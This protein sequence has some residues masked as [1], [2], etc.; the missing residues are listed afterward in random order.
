MGRA[1]LLTGGAG[2]T[3]SFSMTADP[4]LILPT[5]DDPASP[6]V[7]TTPSDED[8]MHLLARVSGWLADVALGARAR[9]EV[10]TAA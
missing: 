3:R 2:D 1:A 9:D 5:A 7:G 4:R 8:A 6:A 10:D